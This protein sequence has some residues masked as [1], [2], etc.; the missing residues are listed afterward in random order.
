MHKW[1]I[2]QHDT[3]SLSLSCARSSS[4]VHLAVLPP[5]PH[6]PVTSPPPPLSQ[7]RDPPPPTVPN[8]HHL[9][10][11]PIVCWLC[12]RQGARRWLWQRAPMQGSRRGW[13]PIIRSP[14]ETTV[15]EQHILKLT[16]PFH[17]LSLQFTSS[18]GGSLKEL[19]ASSLKS[20]PKISPQR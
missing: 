14:L 11:A 16:D 13:R 9:H 3:F 7:S 19:G 18:V 1:S 2:S 8:H 17:I 5:S 15:N 12:Y 10:H 4:T 6:P 20:H